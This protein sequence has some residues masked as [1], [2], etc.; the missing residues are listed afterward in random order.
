MPI[1]K[2]TFALRCFYWFRYE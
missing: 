2:E 1:Q